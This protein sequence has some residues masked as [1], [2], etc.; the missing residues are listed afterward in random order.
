MVGENRKLYEG[1]VNMY[2]EIFERAYE[3]MDISLIDGNCGELCGYHCCRPKHE[4]GESLG[5]YFLPYEYEEMQKGEK[6]IDESTLNIHTNKSYDLPFGIKK[7][8]YGYCKDSSNCIRNIRPIQ[9]R[10]FP[11][12]PHIE[13]GKLMIVIEKNQEHACP[14]IE[15]RTKW[16]KEF[17]SRML[18]AWKELIQIDK[19]KTLVEFDSH[20]RL[21]SKNIL[22]VYNG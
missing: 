20:E 14:L 19:I 2:R 9:C 3:L 11:F 10:T 4:N 8:F 21:D 5:I 6:L 15:D 16:N 22:Y 1:C 17:E 13:D 18:L 7:L 12:V